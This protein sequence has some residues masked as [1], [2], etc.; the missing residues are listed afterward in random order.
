VLLKSLTH[1]NPLVRAAAARSLEPALPASGVRE[2]LSTTL[3]DRSRSVRIAAAWTLRASIDLGSNAGR[4]LRHWLEVN[5]D[6]PVGQ[7]QWGDYL[8]AHNDPQ[9]ALGHY[10]KAVAWDPYSPPFRQQLAAT[11]SALNRPRDA[12][13]TLREC[14]RLN[15]GDAESHYQLGLAYSEAGDLAQTRQEL[16]RTV[17]L[18]PRHSRAW[19]NLGLAQNSLGQPEAAVTSLLRAESASPDDERI[20]YA[21]ATILARLCETKSAIAATR[22]A[23]EINPDY[24]EAR[25]L[26]GQLEQK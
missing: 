23:L 22:R 2:A 21:R 8:L 10:Q 7:L 4:E 17:Q 24:A 9:A 14:C 19:Y 13:E 12:V 16:D 11:F 15:P 1:T 3:T 25:E 5:A 18:N 6:Q 26:L 20:P